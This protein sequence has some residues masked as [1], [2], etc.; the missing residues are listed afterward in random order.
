MLQTFCRVHGARWAMWDLKCPVVTKGDLEL[1]KSYHHHPSFTFKKYYY[2][3]PFSSF[4]LSIQKNKQFSY[5][6]L[7]FLFLGTK[8]TTK[9]MAFSS[10]LGRVLFASIFILSAYQELVPPFLPFSHFIDFY[11]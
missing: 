9:T 4:S 2:L 8:R 3:F 5:F 10:F 1:S 11:L 6:T 7:D